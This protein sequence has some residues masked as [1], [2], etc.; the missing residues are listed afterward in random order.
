MTHPPVKYLFAVLL[1]V[2]L[3]WPSATTAQVRLD[4][5][6]CVG[7]DTMSTSKQHF[8]GYSP[9]NH[10]FDPSQAFQYNEMNC[11][12]SES[13]FL[14]IPD[15]QLFA[16]DPLRSVENE[17]W[18]T[19]WAP[20]TLTE[21]FYNSEEL[22]SNVFS[23]QWD[24]TLSE[25]GVVSKSIHEYNEDGLVTETFSLSYEADLDTFMYSSRSVIEWQDDIVLSNT[26]FQWDST[27]WVP[28]FSSLN[29]IEDGLVIETVSQRYDEDLEMLVNA[30][31]TL[32]EYDDLDRIT[33]FTSFAWFP[34]T[35]GW[36]PSLR[37]TTTYG[38]LSSIETSEFYIIQD[39]SWDLIRTS[40]NTFNEQ[41]QLLTRIDSSFTSGPQIVFGLKYTYNELGFLS[42][43]VRQVQDPDTGGLKD[44]RRTFYT[45]DED[46]D[47]LEIISQIIDEG[48]WLNERRI[49]Y[50]YLPALV[51]NKDEHALS[52]TTLSLYPSPSRG[53]INLEIQLD[54]PSS[55]HIE[56]YDILGRR[57]TTLA[58]ASSV[59][60]TQ[61]FVWQ[62]QNAAAGL[63]F[64]RVQVDE[65][66][67][68]R[69][70]TLIR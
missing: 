38:D 61:H 6:V 33:L 56:V 46:G 69:A 67:E 49:T 55:L 18:T 11:L 70:F 1:T 47:F 27:E 29:T 7:M 16:S 23:S 52:N 3:S 51:S 44:N 2:L 57:V 32:R 22:I 37:R 9:S 14:T 34:D 10:D 15:K 36:L 30:S 39:S 4:H 63:Y 25:Y 31:R 45:S 53:N 20:L 13:D 54:Q 43:F 64:I 21:L 12:T 42:E 5:R 24:T 68:T 35:S 28:G 41:M 59:S 19:E 26:F 17:I 50:T 65:S 8:P 58:K 40:T 48:V 62:P 60:G 66:V